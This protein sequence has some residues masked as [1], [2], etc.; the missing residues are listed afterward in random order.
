MVLRTLIGGSLALVL[1]TQPGTVTLGTPPA[2]RISAVQPPTNAAG[3]IAPNPNAFLDPS[4]LIHRLK[5][6][7]TLSPG[8][9]KDDA[10]VWQQVVRYYEAGQALYDA[11]RYTEALAQF[12]A[13]WQLAA[14]LNNDNKVR[15]LIYIG[16]I[17]ILLNQPQQALDVAT[18][19]LA[20]APTIA[21]PE[22]RS[23][24]LTSGALIA[25]DGH[26]ALSNFSLAID[27]YQ[28][29]L[30]TGGASG[31]PFLLQYASLGLGRLYT[32]GLGQ[33]PQAIDICQGLL[34][35]QGDARNP[36]DEELLSGVLMC[37][38]SAALGQGDFAAATDYYTQVRQVTRRQGNPIGEVYALV[39]LG[40][41]AQRQGDYEQAIAVFTEALPIAQQTGDRLAEAYV[42]G[43]LGH[44]Y[45]Y[46]GEHERAIALLQQALPIARAVGDRQGEF[47][48][49]R[50]LGQALVRQGRP[51]LAIVFYK[52]AVNVSESVRLD[53]DTLPLELQQ[54]FVDTVAVEYRALANLLLEAGRIP[55]AQQVLDLLKLEE[56]REF[57]GTTRATWS[58]DGLVFSDGEQQVIDA[59]GSLIALGQAVYTCEQTTCGELNQ[60]YGQQETLLATYQ[61]QVSAFETTVRDNRAQDLWFQDPSNLSTDAQ[62][63]LD[64]QPDA[65]LI[66]PLVLEDKLWLLWA[67]AG[68]AVGTIEVPVTQATL[69]QTV[70]TLGQLIQS[71]HIN[72][73]NERELQG[74]SRQLYGWLV[75]PL[76][77]ELTANNI[78]HLI[79][80]N[81]RVTRYIPMA[82]LYDG[83]QYLIEQYAISSVLAPAITDTRDRLP[84]ADTAPVLGLGLS[85]AVAGYGPL[86][87]VPVELDAIVQTSAGDRQGIYPGSVFLD[88]AFDLATLREN[89]LD[90]RIL[91]IATHAEFVPGRAE[92][93]FLMLGTGEKLPIADIELLE[94]RFRH[95]H[96]VV[97]SACQTALGGQAGDGSEI[98]GISAYFLEAN[99]AKAVVASLWSVNDTS[100]SLLM[101]RFYA[102][103][104]TGQLSKAEALRQAQLSLL[105][106]TSLDEQLQA[107]ATARG[108]S[109][110]SIG[111]TREINPGG[112]R[113]FTHPYYWAPFILIGN[114]L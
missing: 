34:D 6:P 11:D 99:R 13:A 23:L 33:H 85:Q 79:F 47:L 21:E 46:V 54:S 82:A 108:L 49:L 84:A 20:Y 16:S 39:N 61:Q 91:H 76:A 63:L 44:S 9:T 106:Q 28:A 53:L 57:T 36:L 59:H 43:N 97:L 100:T 101:Q 102:F 8:A 50:S 62:A 60:L 80:V 112:D 107:V 72:P 111:T 38:G 104:A 88:D 67:A 64:A 52:T 48:A 1:G 92:D 74:V 10:R 95:I 12:N 114:S 45:A 93:S 18:D 41:T 2:V 78:E 17:H 40:W 81:D 86:P 24:A 55:E 25:A 71:G 30:A 68:G 87:G 103:M 22:L 56:L 96:L 3:N 35:R 42:I 19:L 66:Y 70:Q 58:S 27:Q 51:E 77:A 73:H 7:L 75:E 94:R 4:H 98:A 90:H 65:V 37:L 32:Y 31:N 83:Q 109:I 14:P 26:L 29:A 105:T 69:A 5:A 110:V 15:I 89:L 113:P